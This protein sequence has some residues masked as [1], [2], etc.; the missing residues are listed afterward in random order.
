MKATRKKTVLKS[1]G[2]GATMLVALM[3]AGMPA[4][5]VK[6]GV[7][8]K[9][10]GPVEDGTLQI[11]ETV[12]QHTAENIG[13]GKDLH[14]G[15]NL[16][17]DADNAWKITIK[18]G[19][20]G[21]IPLFWSVNE[22]NGAESFHHALLEVGVNAD[23]VIDFLGGE[24]YIPTDQTIRTLYVNELTQVQGMLDSPDLAAYLETLSEADLARFH[25]ERADYETKKAEDEESQRVAAKKE[26]D[27]S[28]A[29]RKAE[30]YAVFEKDEAARLSEAKDKYSHAVAAYEASYKTFL[31]KLEQYGKD[32][33][34]FDEA[35]ANY[36]NDVAKY[37]TELQAFRN[38]VA[39]YLPADFDFEKA[40]EE[41]L[42]AVY[43]SAVLEA[44][45]DIGD[46]FSGN[47][48]LTTSSGGGL[49][50][51]VEYGTSQK[52]NSVNGN[53]SGATDA[54]AKGMTLTNGGGNTP[55]KVTFNSS[56]EAGFYSFHAR[57]NGTI[58]LITFELTEA[59]VEYLHNTGK[60][61]TVSF[62]EACQAIQGNAT[63]EVFLLLPP[64]NPGIFDID[65]PD[66][67]EKPVEPEFEF[68]EGIFSFV[69]KEF[70]F[71][72]KSFD[73]KFSFIA[74]PSDETQSSEISEE[75]QTSE[76]T[77]DSGEESQNSDEV[78]GSG[79]EVQT[80]DETSDSGEE[81]QNSE[82]TSYSVEEIQTSN[83]SSEMSEEDKNSDTIEG[84][85]VSEESF[86]ASEESRNSEETSD[87]SEE[88][89]T[90]EVSEEDQDS[91]KMSDS[92][93]GTH[94]S[95]EESESGE[96]TPKASEDSQFSE[97]ISGVSEN[98]QTSERTS[99]TNRESQNSDQIS[100]TSEMS[101]NSTTNKQEEI[102]QQESMVASDSVAIM[103]SDTATE[104]LSAVRAADGEA[105]VAVS[106]DENVAADAVSANDT[107]FVVLS[108]D[109]AGQA[110]VAGIAD[111][112]VSAHGSMSPA[113]ELTNENHVDIDT[114]AKVDAL[115]RREDEHANT[116]YPDV[117]KTT[118]YVWMGNIP[119]QEGNNGQV[120]I[121]INGQ[122]F[123][124]ALDEQEAGTTLHQIDG[125]Q[126][127][128]TAND[129]ER[130]V[131]IVVTPDD[132]QIV[133]H[134][135]HVHGLV[136][137]TAVS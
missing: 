97:E 16:S 115:I 32:E 111:D 29:D 132:A 66:L 68:E 8:V 48:T 17:I 117:N 137:D 46:T 130:L 60:S 31:E 108:A 110:E 52:V 84:S 80:S 19:Y 37:Q 50:L 90:S 92:G 69:D 71:V 36:H 119:L 53:A 3:L 38:A 22:D 13:A 1:L 91:D 123:I 79:E 41:Q 72:A 45:K 106:A 116:P 83:D 135:I 6:A 128:M 121:E 25:E 55:P 10:E 33:A 27:Q 61:V 28:E 124:V 125:Y 112:L 7:K 88:N 93:E 102:L 62:P 107:E 129:D 30:E 86:E 81:I 96:E 18:N 40:T 49:T 133:V 14:E 67:P 23:G 109:E 57:V 103:T 75:A 76:D 51:N 114:E 95:D 20:G 54:L 24:F 2:V 78:S 113:G 126:L 77:S 127:D 99:E 65:K 136:T 134:S 101:E 74:S 21:E 98:S 35:W 42:K 5:N 12:G 64:S 58:K 87:S 44:K 104:N 89:Q 34:E 82:E 70:K 15:V 85:Q 120:R 26:F 59:D 56:A 47:S 122:N 9:D 4:K 118:A 105:R 100:E 131:K 43:V 63:G 11:I 39:R 94:A 73:E